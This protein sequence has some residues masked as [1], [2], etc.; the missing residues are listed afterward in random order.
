[1]SQVANTSHKIMTE[2]IANSKTIFSGFPFVIIIVIIITIAIMIIIYRTF[3]FTCA[4]ICVSS[5]CL[6]YAIG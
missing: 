3:N 2:D 4:S 6:S 1:M 5:C